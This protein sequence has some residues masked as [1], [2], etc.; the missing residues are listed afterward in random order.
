MQ[1]WGS[2]WL[3]YSCVIVFS[4][5]FSPYFSYARQFTDLHNS[6]VI[7]K[8]TGFHLSIG[9]HPKIRYRWQVLAWQGEEDSFKLTAFW[10]M[11]QLVTVSQEL[12][13]FSTGSGNVTIY[14]VSWKTELNKNLSELIHLTL[15]SL[16]GY[17]LTWCWRISERADESETYIPCLLFIYEPWSSERSVL[18]LFTCC[19]DAI[20]NIFGDQHSRMKGQHHR[21]KPFLNADRIQ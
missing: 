17:T 12:Q 7:N 16:A 19:S 4:F 13:H 1:A 2:R 20:A 14:Q 3:I 18:V 15:P 10:P 8:M 21:D 6:V 5:S 9:W 11:G